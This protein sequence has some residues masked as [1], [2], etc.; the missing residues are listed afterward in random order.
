MVNLRVRPQGAWDFRSSIGQPFEA[1]ELVTASTAQGTLLERSQVLECETGGAQRSFS[2]DETL[3]MKACEAPSIPQR[4]C[5][6]RDPQTTES[7]SPG[8]A[9]QAK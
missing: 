7:F 1:I 5:R 4:L 3:T 2:F 9:S 8:T 6:Q